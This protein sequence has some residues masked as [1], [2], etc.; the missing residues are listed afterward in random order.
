MD[1]ME[2]AR[3]VV[4]VKAFWK[5]AGREPLGV[6]LCG[7]NAEAAD[8]AWRREAE[9]WLKHIGLSNR[10]GRTFSKEDFIREHPLPEWWQELAGDIPGIDDPILSKEIKWGQKHYMSGSVRQTDIPLTRPVLS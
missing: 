9:R 8:D 6:E 2:I 5:S 4:V 1:R 7:G 10:H 3:A